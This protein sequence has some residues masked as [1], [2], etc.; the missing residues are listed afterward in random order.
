MDQIGVCRIDGRDAVLE[1]RKIRIGISVYGYL[2]RMGAIVCVQD[3]RGM[4]PFEESIGHL[5]YYMGK[6][7]D[8]LN[9]ANEV[10]K[11]IDAIECGEW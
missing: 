2:K 4:I 11:R 5:R 8:D 10:K 9:W 1:E 6:I 3:Q 7:H